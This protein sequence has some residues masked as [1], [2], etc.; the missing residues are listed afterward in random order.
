MGRPRDIDGPQPDATTLAAARHLLPLYLDRVYAHAPAVA[1]PAAAQHHHQLRIAAKRLRY[2]MENFAFLFS[3]EFQN[4]IECTRKIQDL[5]GRV[6]DCD[7]L[8][9]FF[10]SYLLDRRRQVEEELGRALLAGEESPALATLE[11]VRQAVAPGVTSAEHDAVLRLI[12]R[13]RARRLLAFAE[14]QA[15]W[16]ELDERG[17]RREILT[18]IGTDPDLRFGSAVS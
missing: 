5:L 15:F 3:P 16:L 13:T 12:E 4:L 9:A 7:M 8:V 1:D 17:F 18:A 10:E 14:F 2:V 6:R 11:D